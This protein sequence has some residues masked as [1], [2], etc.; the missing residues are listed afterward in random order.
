M[1]PER[2][3]ILTEVVEKLSLATNL[4]TISQVVAEAARELT[5]ADG[6]SFILREGDLS[7]YAD[8][9]AIAPLWKG[10][11][12]PL[13]NC[14]SGWSILHRQAVVIA[15]IYQDE[16]IPHSLYRPT[17]VKSLTMVPIRI[18]DPTGAIGCYWADGHCPSEEELKLLQILANSAAIA[19]ENY[20]LKE[21]L[22][23]GEKQFEAAMH[24]LA[25]DLKNPISTMVLFAELLREHLG[26][27]LDD[28]MRAYIESILETGTFAA[29]QISKMLSL[30]SV[31]NCKVEKKKL[32][33]S[34]MAYEISERL[35]A[36]SPGR[37]IQV[38]IE[39]NLLAFADPHLIQLA[40]ENLFSN[41]MKYTGKKPAARIEFGKKGPEGANEFFVGDNG[42]GFAEDQ[43]HRL[44]QPLV[45]L[46]K[47]HEFPGT[48]LG[49][50]SVAKVVE[51]H[52]GHVRAEGF[53][54]EGATFYFTLPAYLF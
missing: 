5:G 36:H 28:K 42:D 30:Y 52:G 54:G 33:L 31:R 1:K 32:N 22:P 20:Q 38:E 51:L 53:K 37:N 10:S 39:P 43:A 41:A 46:H 3:R 45:R 18:E 21:T 9:S 23:L 15:D 40:L 48:G 34:A 19:L 24:T 13:E 25:H 17:F 26:E 7:Y 29:E 49:L 14:I 44:F 4:P 50:A 27:R 47:D 8:E 11:K 16:R 35:K 12:F 2:A 6:V